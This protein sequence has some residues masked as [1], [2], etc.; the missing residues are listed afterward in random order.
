VLVKVKANLKAIKLILIHPLNY[1][2]PFATISLGQTEIN[3]SMHFDHD[4]YMGKM[5]NLK[6]FD[7]TNYPKTLDPTIKY[8]EGD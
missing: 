3:Y 4:V 7:N 1:T 6:I 8:Q 5:G 2:Y